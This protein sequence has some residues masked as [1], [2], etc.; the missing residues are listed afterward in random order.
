MAKK[1]GKEGM[2]KVYYSLFSNIAHGLSFDE[3]VGFT[4]GN[5]VYKPIRNLMKLDQIFRNSLN[6]AFEIYQKML[7]YYRLEEIEN[8]KRKYISEWRNRFISIKKIE[9]KNG[10]YTISEN[11]I[12]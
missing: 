2:Y 12:G 7:K 10:A 4:K 6:F 8:F 11:K 1:V 9:Y 3:Q 5:V